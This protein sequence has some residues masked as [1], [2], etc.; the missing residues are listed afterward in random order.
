M[1][2]ND[3]R[4]RV[5]AWLAV[6]AVILHAATT[7]LLHWL[8]PQVDPVSEL[9]TA[10]LSS[11]YQVL[12][13]VGGLAFGCA[14]GSLAVGLYFHRIS[15]VWFKVALVL[16][17]VAVIGFLVLAA[18]PDAVGF[19]AGAVRPA[20]VLTVLVLSLRL[21]RETP[22]QVVG[23]YLLAM[24]IGVVSL[25]VLLGIFLSAGLGGLANR[26]VLV[27]LYTW[28]LLVSRGLLLTPVQEDAGAT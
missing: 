11:E 12:S 27:L 24:V 8:V 21:R 2:G 26:V 13:R 4:S 7:V 25:F 15:G 20:M 6:S 14:M 10:Y 18:A 23:P 1:T 22:W 3:S 9:M 5:L 17:A 28:I 16:A 19:L